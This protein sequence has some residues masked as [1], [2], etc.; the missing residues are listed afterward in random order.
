MRSFQSRPPIPIAIIGSV[1]LG[2]LLVAAYNV[3][4]LP[5]I[6]KGKVYRA[7]FSNAAGLRHGDP[8]KIAGVIVGHVDQVKLKGKH[9]EVT[10]DTGGAW[11]GD[12]S[13]ASVQLNTLLGQRYLAIVPTGS[14]KLDPD[15]AIP[16]D[17][18]ETPYEIVPTLNKL[19]ETLGDIDVQKLRA[20]FDAVSDTFSGTPQ[21]VRGA[22]TGLSRLSRTVATRD[23][24]LQQMLQ[25]ANAVATTIGD[26]DAQVAALVTD[27]D[28]LLSELQ[29]RRDAIHGLLVG[30]QVLATQ[31]DGL[32]ADNDQTLRPA[33]DQLAQVAGVLEKNQQN[34]EAGIKVL[35]P[36]T[37]LFSNTVGVGRWFDAYVCGMVPLSFGGVN[38]KGC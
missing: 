17:R 9:V 32:V 15:V 13:H 5:L 4:N 7:E 36:Y 34:L 11:I 27:L 8:A 10:F 30:A 37:H 31:L 3:G 18:T 33:L 21:H 19:S 22:L 38:E 6:G 23:A 16:L 29:K 28:P 20:A 24:E 1:L 2:V 25:R 35:A 14:K 26:R 12:T